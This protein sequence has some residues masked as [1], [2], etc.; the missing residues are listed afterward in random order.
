MRRPGVVDSGFFLRWRSAP[1]GG[2]ARCHEPA[3]KYRPSTRIR[4]AAMAAWS[5]RSTRSP[6]NRPGS[7]RWPGRSPEH[8]A[9]GG[10]GVQPGRLRAHEHHL[11][12][13]ERS[14]SGGDRG[15]GTHRHPGPTMKI[16]DIPAEPGTRVLESPSKVGTPSPHRRHD[17]I[18][19]GV[20][21]R[22]LSCA[23]HAAGTSAR[24]APSARP[25][26]RA[27]S[28]RQGLVHPGPVCGVQRT[29]VNNALR[30]KPRESGPGYLTT[31]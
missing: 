31:T 26:V 20:R 1:R 11:H 21:F 25:G 28:D 14:A 3:T 2:D 22:A 8:A 5:P 16:R 6:T 30:A 15:R 13:A 24:R 12:L 9:L 10:A 27:R 4:S 19:P 18:S 7:T 23:D 17:A 29:P